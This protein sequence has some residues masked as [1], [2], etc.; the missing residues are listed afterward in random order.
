MALYGHNRSAELALQAFA[1]DL[2]NVAILAIP[3]FKAIGQGAFREKLNSLLLDRF[4][5]TQT[6]ETIDLNMF[7]IDKFS[8]VIQVYEYANDNFLSITIVH[9]NYK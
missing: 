9:V 6:G 2:D 3:E 1:N 7:L 4:Q 8:E 5:M